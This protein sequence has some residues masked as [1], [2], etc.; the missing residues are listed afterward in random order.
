MLSATTVTPQIPATKIPKKTE[1]FASCNEK[2]CRLINN[3][4]G[5]KMTSK[6]RFLHQWFKKFGPC[7][8]ILILMLSLSAF[9]KDTQTRPVTPEMVQR[10]ANAVPALRNMMRDPDSF[11]LERVFQL[12]VVKQGNPEKSHNDVCYYYRSRN[13]FGGYQ[14]G[15][16]HLDDG[17]KLSDGGFTCQL[18]TEPKYWK[19][20]ADI[21]AEVQ[22]AI[23]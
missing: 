14:S 12:V 15:T 18:P 17:G 13:G 3:G 5:R 1:P 23:K 19:N 16:A 20:W 7:S 4:V 9:A 2:Q 22:A 21:T 10:A 6:E 11:V 8:G